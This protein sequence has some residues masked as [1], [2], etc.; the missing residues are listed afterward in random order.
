MFFAK[1]EN[2][3]I[4]ELQV[5]IYYKFKEIKNKKLPRRLSAFSSPPV[6]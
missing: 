2:V 4:I 6:S 1:S 5:N 3:K